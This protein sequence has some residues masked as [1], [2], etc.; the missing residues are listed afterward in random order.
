MKNFKII[1][2]IIWFWSTFNPTWTVLFWK[3]QGWVE[4]LV[5][6]GWHKLLYL[7]KYLEKCFDIVHSYW[8]N[9]RQYKNAKM[10]SQT[11]PSF[12]NDVIINVMYM[13]S[14]FLTFYWRNNHIFNVNN[15]YTYL[16]YN[17]RSKRS[18]MQQ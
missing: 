18:M 14:F 3:S 2:K 9:Y 4:C 10:I 17:A 8:T 7:K 12:L 1:G 16:R 13:F 11:M 5:Y 6:T 15:I